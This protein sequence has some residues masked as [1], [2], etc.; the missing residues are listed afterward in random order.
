MPESKNSET[1]NKLHQII[2]M[3]I[4]LNNA[5]V[6]NWEDKNLD[7]DTAVLIETSEAIDSCSWKWW[8]KTENDIENLKVEAVD[9]LHF[10]ISKLLIESRQPHEPVDQTEF[11]VTTLIQG[12][13]LSK[14]KEEY[15]T[16]EYNTDE[17]I[18][19]LKKIAFHC[20]NNDSLESMKSLIKVFDLLGMT[21]N[22]VYIGYMS[23]NLLN[24]YRQER[25]YKTNGEYSELNNRKGYVKNFVNHHG[26]FEDNV[27]F[28]KVVRKVD[29]MKDD[30]ESNFLDKKEIFLEMDKIVDHY[31]ATG[32]FH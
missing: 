22:E 8:K 7:W 23:K 27:I 15:F 17:I 20:L 14:L 2:S 29:A 19:N 26:S 1:Y 21:F 24:H 9:L 31:K 3:Q 13:V 16:Q 6:K 30:G 28:K 11:I 10:L 4:D 18:K 25:G 5:T 32:F 12:F